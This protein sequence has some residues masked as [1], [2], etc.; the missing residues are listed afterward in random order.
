ML[1]FTI[2]NWKDKLPNTCHMILQYTNI[3]RLFALVKNVENNVS[4]QYIIFIV[5]ALDQLM[6]FNFLLHLYIYQLI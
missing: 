1:V 3:N 2:K 6:S 5:C 4:T